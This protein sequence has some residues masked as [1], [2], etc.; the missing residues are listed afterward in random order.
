MNTTSIP[1]MQIIFKLNEIAFNRETMLLLK[2]PTRIDIYHD[3]ETQQLLV[4]R[5][6]TFT[7][8]E[9]DHRRSDQGRVHRFI[10]EQVVALCKQ[11]IQKNPKAILA[12]TVHLPG[13]PSHNISYLN[14]KY[15]TDRIIFGII[16]DLARYKN[17]SMKDVPDVQLV[18]PKELV[19][20]EECAS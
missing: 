11:T 10:D 12:N 5:G 15:R 20:H 8:F 14:E 6:S 7:V 13:Y 3:D 2:Q 18:K 16:F 1:I 4:T 9:D 19:V 17:V